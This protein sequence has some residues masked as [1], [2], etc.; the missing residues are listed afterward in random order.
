MTKLERSI[1]GPKGRQYESQLNFRA[2]IY[3]S[4]APAN[5]MLIFLSLGCLLPASYARSFPLFPPYISLYLTL[6]IGED[7]RDSW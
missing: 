3:V 5:F 2:N 6:L 7:E 4:G 1:W